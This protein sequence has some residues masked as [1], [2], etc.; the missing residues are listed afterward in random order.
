MIPEYIERDMA[1]L[2]AYVRLVTHMTVAMDLTADG[3]EVR[4]SCEQCGQLVS[5]SVLPLGETAP[6]R[7]DGAID[8]TLARLHRAR[9]PKKAP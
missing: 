4:I 7:I 6:A 9:C 1:P 8:G 3:I 5:R 2:L